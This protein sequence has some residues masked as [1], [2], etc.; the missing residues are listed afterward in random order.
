M[1][2]S[3]AI[4]A[5]T[6]TISALYR[7]RRMVT[8]RISSV[9]S[10]FCCSSSSR[11]SSFFSALAILVTRS[12]RGRRSVCALAIART[13]RRRVLPAYAWGTVAWKPR[14]SDTG[15]S[16][17]SASSSDVSSAVSRSAVAPSRMR[18]LSSSTPTSIEVMGWFAGV[19]APFRPENCSSDELILASDRAGFS[20]ENCGAS[21]NVDRFSGYGSREAESWPACRLTLVSA[22]TIAGVIRW[23]AISDRSRLGSLAAERGASISLRCD[24]P[25]ERCIRFTGLSVERCMRFTGLSGALGHTIASNKPLCT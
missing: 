1:A 8:L 4:L 14:R 11:D 19:R 2:S 21:S 16:S 24:E 13:L 25:V 20:I 9:I 7:F 10:A 17:R 22:L 6:W 3:A 15:T 5:S 18:W 23:G 12:R